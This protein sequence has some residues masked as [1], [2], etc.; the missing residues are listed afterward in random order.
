MKSPK[1]KKQHRP[2]ILPLW[3]WAK[4]ERNAPG[5]TG[6]DGEGRDVSTLDLTGLQEDLIKAVYESGT[7][8]IVILVNGRPL[9]IEWI[10]ENVPG[11]VEAWNCGEQGG[12]AIADV[13][14]GDYNPSGRLPV[15]IPRTVGQLPSYYNFPSSKGVT[16]VR[17]YAN[18]PK[19][20]LY[21][22][23]FGLSYTTF[24]YSNLSITPQESGPEGEFH[25]SLDLSN[26]GTRTGAEVVQLYIHDEISSVTRPIKELRGFEKVALNPGE[27]KRVEF[28]LGPEHLSFFD[29]NLN[30]VVEP[31]T[32]AVMVGSSSNDIKLKGIIKVR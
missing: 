22:F 28:T 30:K 7:P 25:V 12:N 23:G 31:G 19:T 20:P 15:T 10:S 27:K 3:L 11:I 16:F 32:F 24:E 8:V 17:G 4:M 13:L 21:V 14:F 9:S 29:Q 2:Q 5:G 6:T 26:T 18:G 1:P